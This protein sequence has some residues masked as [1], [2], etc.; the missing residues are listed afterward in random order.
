MLFRGVFL[1]DK[2]LAWTS[3]FL[4]GTGLPPGRCVLSNHK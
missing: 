1:T 3:D 2:I 4:R